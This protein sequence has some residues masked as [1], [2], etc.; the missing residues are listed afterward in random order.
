[1]TDTTWA[2]ERWTNNNAESVNN[3]LKLSA[4]WKVLP[5]SS[6]IDNVFDCVRVQYADVWR[7]L[8]GRGN[9]TVA[10]EFSHNA[11]NY[12][13]WQAADDDR[14]EEY[15]RRFMADNGQRAYRR[16]HPPAAATVITSTDGVTRTPAT[17][18]AARKPGQRTRPAATRARS[19]RRR[20]LA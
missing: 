13:D 8:S 16:E 17:G 11:V 4:E 15:F 5:T 1:V 18:R 20:K 14:K 10:P 2:G 7:A 3:L 6:I 9:F 12:C 19:T